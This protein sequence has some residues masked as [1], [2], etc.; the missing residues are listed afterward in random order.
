MSLMLL[1]L[2]KKNQ[3]RYARAVLRTGP[4]RGQIPVSAKPAKF[5]RPV[6]YPQRLFR[7]YILGEI[8]RFSTSEN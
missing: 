8:R 6:S 4:L 5:C 7:R 2:S 1:Y 3:A